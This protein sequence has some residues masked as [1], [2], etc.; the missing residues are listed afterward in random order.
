MQNDPFMETMPKG[1]GY[2]T[3]TSNSAALV[4]I[5]EDIANSLPMAIVQ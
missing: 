4:T 5:F 2:Y 1:I 3:N